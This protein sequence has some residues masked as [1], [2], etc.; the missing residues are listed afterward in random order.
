M[1][2]IFLA[3]LILTENSLVVQWL[4]LHALTAEDAGSISGQGTNIPRAMH[5]D[6][7][8]KHTHTHKNLILI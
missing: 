5:H 2:W 3:K 6:Q 1:E 7:K 8:A 4:G